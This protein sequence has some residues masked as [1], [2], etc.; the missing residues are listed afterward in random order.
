MARQRRHVYLV[1]LSRV[2]HHLS[3][4]AAAAA[5]RPARCLSSSSFSAGPA[6]AAPAD[7]S[8]I[9]DMAQP[10][11]TA[12]D[13]AKFERDGFWVWDGVMTPECRA[14]LTGALKDVQKTQDEM[15]MDARWD[16]M[17]AADYAALG[18]TPPKRSYSRA[19][20]SQML[21]SSQVTSGLCDGIEPTKGLHAT[22]TPH[23][24]TQR[25]DET[26]T[27]EKKYRQHMA[28]GAWGGVWPEHF[29][30]G[31]SDHFL[32]MTC[33]PQMLALHRLMLGDELPL[34]YDH[35]VALNRQ[36]GFAGQGWHSHGVSLVTLLVTLLARAC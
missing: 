9:F 31:Y 2:G 4:S 34:R 21:G 6:G 23:P 12:F 25:P 14:Q 16:E 8:S 10:C 13:H 32:D 24:R 5:V 18:L 30:C 28:L 19:E 11:V 22:F 20:R 33:H 29:P 15:V 26:L 3:S 17:Q 27:P 7:E 1:R 35:V 36:G